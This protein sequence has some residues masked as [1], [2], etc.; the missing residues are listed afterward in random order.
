MQQE[1]K[2][3]GFDK[4][5]GL[6]LLMNPKKKLGGDNFSVGSGS[7]VEDDRASVKSISFKP[8]VIN[9][10]DHLNDN[11]YDDDH[12][13]DEDDGYYEDDEDD[14]PPKQT[15][16]KFGGGVPSPGPTFNR[17]VV[18]SSSGD[19]GGS[20]IESLGIGSLMHDQRRRLSEEDV[21]LMKKELLYQFERLE[22]KG[23]KLPKKFT[24][25]SNL[26]EMRME[27]DRLK[28]D[29][30]VD[31]SIKFQRR[32]IMATVSGVEWMNGKWD[33]LGAKL[34]GWS[35]SIYEN[36]N[37]Y[38]DIFEELHEKYKG[39]AKIAPELKLMMMLGGSAFMH[40]MTHS[41]FKSQ[42]PGLDEILRQNP[43][44][45]KNLAAA[46]SQHMAHQ[47]KSAGNLFGSIGTMF[48]GF[49]GGNGGMPNM[50]MPT[51]PVPPPSQP[52]A[53]TVRVNMKGPSNVEDILKEF[54]NDRIE[55]MSAITESELAELTADDTSSIN[56]L[57]MSSASKKKS[58]RGK[59]ISLDI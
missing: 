31:A 51:V 47:Q 58:K 15:H 45:A 32:I 53:T 26:E 7:G 8:A 30:E 54:D 22:K 11:D 5:L 2:F 17:G 41:M 37:D 25:A 38:D 34:D 48:S 18:E 35:D 24:L 43:D 46:T 16:F 21:I 57:L 29:K 49:F 14:E 3:G 20:Q 50:S 10:A 56:G 52:A 6:E 28:R 12:E 42:L 36:I 4:D 40:H 39:K 55:L 27:Y 19:D 33:P 9:V 59:G 13:D 44:L 1:P 23:M